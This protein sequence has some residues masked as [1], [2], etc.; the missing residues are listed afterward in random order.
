MDMKEFNALVYKKYG[1]PYYERHKNVCHKRMREWREKNREAYNRIA[2]ESY[3]RRKD[4]E[5]RKQQA[6]NNGIDGLS[7]ER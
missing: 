7:S 4:A 2:R 6:D 1:K 5:K 3:Y